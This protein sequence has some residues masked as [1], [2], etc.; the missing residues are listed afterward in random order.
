MNPDGS[1]QVN[2]TNT[3]D[4]W[5]EWPFWSPDGQKIGYTAVVGSADQIRVMNVDGTGQMPLTQGQKDGHADWSPDG[6]RIIFD[7][8]MTPTESVGH[9]QLH[10]MSADGTNVQRLTYSD[11]DDT[12]AAWCPD[13]TKVVF[14]STRNG[15]YLREQIYVADF[16]V[17]ADGNAQLL[18]QTNVTANEWRHGQPRWS[19]DGAK[20]VF[21]RSA[22]NRWRPSDLW[23]MDWDGGGEVQLTNTPYVAEGGPDWGASPQIEPRRLRNGYDAPKNAKP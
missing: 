20:I 18:N 17:D 23:I 5:E 1:G 16:V 19:P 22:Y 13:G 6:R 14:S 10:V 7:R 11:L 8:A 3:P 2:L 9:W 15:D 12:A 4:I 21:G